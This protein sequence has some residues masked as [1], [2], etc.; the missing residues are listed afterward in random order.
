[1][2]RNHKA[3]ATIGTICIFFY[4]VQYFNLNNKTLLLLFGVVFYF[5]HRTVKNYSLASLITYLLFLP[6]EKGKT[7]GFTLIPGWEMG[8]GKNYLYSFDILFSDIAFFVLFIFTA[9]NPHSMQPQGSHKKPGYQQW[10]LF[11]FLFFALFAIQ[12][13]AIPII[14]SM[15]FI[16]LARMVYAYFII[17]KFSSRLLAVQ[18]I[19][20]AM[21]TS[22]IFESV[23]AIAQYVMGSPLGKSIEYLTGAFSLYGQGAIE[24][25][26]FY[27]PQG[28]FDHPNT[29][30]TFLALNIAFFLPCA[31]AKN[32]TD[33][34]R[35]FYGIGIF[36]AG[37]GLIISSSRAAWGSLIL[38]F[39]WGAYYIRRYKNSIQT[40]QISTL[41]WASCPFIF[42]LIIKIVIPRLQQLASTLSQGGGLDYRMFLIEKAWGMFLHW[43]FGIGLGMFPLMLFRG[44]PQVGIIAPIHNL[45]VEILLEIG[46]L[47][48]VAFASFVTLSI[49]AAVIKK[50]DDSTPQAHLLHIGSF[51]AVAVF[52]FL[53]NFYPFLWSSQ[54]FEYFW[55]FIGLMI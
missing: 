29:L 50:S 48:F 43:P 39:F 14:S 40:K 38:I 22:M 53:A 42:L 13:S 37:A 5:L 41:F 23:W 45:F 36:L 4:A 3:L 11:A 18:A 15:A 28:T 19:P 20:I 12:F 27:R 47:G 49:W 26:R 55:L 32:Q 25:Y 54:I 33:K 10:F 46:V 44:F 17:R 8:I 52:L 21:A 9:L 6:F 16:R 7:F 30:G 51:A 34:S 31:L 2:N 35:L 1:M 24:D